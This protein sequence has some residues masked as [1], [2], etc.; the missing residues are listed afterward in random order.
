MFKLTFTQW[1]KFLKYFTRL[2]CSVLISVRFDVSRWTE[3]LEKN[4][5]LIFVRCLTAAGSQNS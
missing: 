5:V 1:K 4:C 3:K 2:K